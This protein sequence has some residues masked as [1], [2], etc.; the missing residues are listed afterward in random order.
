MELFLCLK[1]SKKEVL[2]CNKEY[3]PRAWSACKSSSS[4]KDL[5]CCATEIGGSTI[6]ATSSA[7]A[8]FANACKILCFRSFLRKLCRLKS[9]QQ[10]NFHGIQYRK[11]LK[12]AEAF[13]LVGCKSQTFNLFEYYKYKLELGFWFADALLLIKITKLQSTNK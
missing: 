7:P 13:N 11:L 1:P 10:K 3:S 9:Q 6:T 8:A 12:K 5:S 4:H 2:F